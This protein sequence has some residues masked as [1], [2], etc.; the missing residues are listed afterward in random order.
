MNVQRTLLMFGLGK[1][2]DLILIDQ[3]RGIQNSK[4]AFAVNL[5]HPVVDLG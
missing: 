4:I 3:L 5:K 1:Y 2:K